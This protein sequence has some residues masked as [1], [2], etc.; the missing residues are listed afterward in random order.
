MR[1]WSVS[2][3]VQGI[4][5]FVL[6][7]G[8]LAVEIVVHHLQLRRLGHAG[9]AK[10]VKDVDI[11]HGRRLGGVLQHGVRET[12]KHFANL[13][14]E[15]GEEAV[16]AASGGCNNVDDLVEVLLRSNSKGVTRRRLH[17]QVLSHR[18]GALDELLEQSRVEQLHTLAGELRGH[19]H[20][21]LSRYVPGE[22]ESYASLGG[23][24]GAVAQ[25]PYSVLEPLLVSADVVPR[26]VMEGGLNNIVEL[27][28][29]ATDV[30]RGEEALGLAP[31]GCE[32][33]IKRSEE[34][35]EQDEAVEL[36]GERIGGIISKSGEFDSR[37]ESQGTLV[38]DSI[39]SVWLQC[40]YRFLIGRKK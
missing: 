3:Q 31:V 37:L 4:L 8:K 24:D 7:D 26:G 20:E 27:L 6:F 38:S 40:Q 17:R 10:S 19:V 34:V 13:A 15:K 32:G 2:I 25:L 23:D 29:Q 39:R 14:H 16:V 22:L 1:I 33:I 5:L 28:L 12:R 21:Q 9:V 35:D 30:L 11:G 18:I 36:M